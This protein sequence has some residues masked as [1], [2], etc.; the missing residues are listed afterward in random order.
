MSHRSLF[1][2]HLPDTI[3]RTHVYIILARQNSQRSNDH[4]KPHLG[5]LAFGSL[6]TENAVHEQLTRKKRQSAGYA[7]NSFFSVRAFAVTLMAS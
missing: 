2:S 4:P 6:R 5:L 1:F 3:P 7:A